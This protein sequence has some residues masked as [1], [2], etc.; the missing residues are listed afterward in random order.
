[1]SSIDTEKREGLRLLSGLE[2]GSMTIADAYTIADKRDPVVVYFVLRFLREKYPPSS[3]A[4]SGVTGRL[5]EL[6]STYDDLVKR[7]RQG[8]RDSLREWFDD[9]YNLR[10]FF[11]RPAELVDLIVDKIEG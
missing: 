4:G 5:V 2:S 7:S 8:E 9:T 1:M 11:D 6:T 10:E 3:A